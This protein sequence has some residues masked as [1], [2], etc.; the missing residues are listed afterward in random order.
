M[1]LRRISAIATSLTVLVFCGAAQG[2]PQTVYFLCWEPHA[3]SIGEV[4]LTFS[5]QIEVMDDYYRYRYVELSPP[6]PYPSWCTVDRLKENLTSG[7]GV[8]LYAGHG[9]GDLLI[10]TGADTYSDQRLCQGQMY[11][12]LNDDDYK[13]SYQPFTSGGN[14]YYYVIEY[15]PEITNNDYE[16][17]TEWCKSWRAT[18]H[19]VA[20]SFSC[21]SF[22]Q[23]MRCFHTAASFGY[24]VADVHDDHARTDITNL[25]GRMNGT[26]GSGAYLSAQA[27]HAHYSDPNPPTVNVY[28]ET[29]AV[30][31]L[32]PYVE[33]AA[34]TGTG[35]GELRYENCSWV[36]YASGA[37]LFSDDMKPGGTFTNG[38]APV[39]E[40]GIE[41]SRGTLPNHPTPVSPGIPSGTPNPA[42]K[43]TSPGSGVTREIRFV[44]RADPNTPVTV[45]VS[46]ENEADIQ[47]GSLYLDGD[48][49]APNKDD[50]QYDF[51]TV[52]T[53]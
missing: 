48:K 32:F 17:S 27:A 34:P 42:W 13:V 21:G 50:Y 4:G 19:G 5:S 24:G 1:T 7:R 36:V 40:G 3:W 25:F 37:V 28:P 35:A 23:G 10:Y 12:Y 31:R 53:N 9:G 11:D 46:G 47:Q 41:F 22:D 30:E 43:E 6:E 45:T 29:G 52:G 51:T 2:L 14:P 26:I 8:V 33:L 20:F 39:A 44:L 49:I 16:E 38:Y 18:P 15:G